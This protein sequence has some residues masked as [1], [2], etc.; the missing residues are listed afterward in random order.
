MR[1]CVTFKHSLLQVHEI[2]VAHKIPH[3]IHAK[4]GRHGSPKRKMFKCPP[5]VT[6]HDDLRAIKTI[7]KYS[8]VPIIMVLS[9]TEAEYTNLPAF[10]PDSPVP[11]LDVKP[12]LVLPSIMDYVNVA[13]KPSYLM[14]IQTALYRISNHNTRK[15]AQA[16][17][18]KYLDNKLSWRQL[19]LLL[20]GN[21][22]TEPL[23]R[24]LACDEAEQLKQAVSSV[25][26]G[27]DVKE[28]AAITDFCTFDIL[29]IIR[30]SEKSP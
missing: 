8:K 30:S 3:S 4:A 18:I 22:A 29:Y 2:L 12:E 6:V 16:A 26:A 14:N 10:D 15:V 11:T 7:G 20:T 17:V 27:A 24:I 19:K 5:H 9:K 25:R 23:V 1:G 21:L 13:V 28:V